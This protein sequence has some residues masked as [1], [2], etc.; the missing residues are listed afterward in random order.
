MLLADGRSGAADPASKAGPWSPES[1]S[2]VPFL[3]HRCTI[4]S[5][6]HRTPRQGAP[7]EPAWQLCGVISVRCAR[8]G[9]ILRPEADK[10]VLFPRTE[11]ES[12]AIDGGS[13]III[14]AKRHF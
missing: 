8:M 11:R 10:H 5:L 7:I 14:Q 12:A 9:I 6:H 4:R 3:D 1:A 13:V 2:A